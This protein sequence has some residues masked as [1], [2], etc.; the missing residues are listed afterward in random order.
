MRAQPEPLDTLTLLQREFAEALDTSTPFP[1]LAAPHHAH[2]ERL[3]LYRSSV[4]SHRNTA[5]AGAYPVL[6]ALVGETYF[7]ALGAAYARVHPSQSG[8][9]NAFGASLADFIAGYERQ[10]RLRYIADLARLEWALHRAHFAADAPALTPRAW[11]AIHPDDLLDARV[12]IHPACA[13]VASPYAVGDIWSAHR[14]GAPLPAD[15]DTPNR[16]LVVRPRWHAEIRLQTPAAHAAFERLMN[17]AR[18]NDALDAA[19]ALDS[20]FDFVAQWRVWIE[21]SAIT[22]LA[23]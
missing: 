13:L 2:R 1:Q 20:A 21:A 17:G 23:G 4:H 16:V 3:D 8:D 9:L 10:P 22:G 14:T 11:A 18:L 15:P 5:L 19:F 6:L 7:D 12:A